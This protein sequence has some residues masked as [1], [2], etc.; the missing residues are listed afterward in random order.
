MNGVGMSVLGGVAMVG[1]LHFLLPTTA[2]T[3]KAYSDVNILIKILIFRIIT[4]LRSARLLL[5][6]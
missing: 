4:G 5:S 3:L 1:V 2:L 6:T